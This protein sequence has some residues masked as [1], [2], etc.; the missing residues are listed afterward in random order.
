MGFKRH[1]NIVNLPM[2][3]M[4]DKQIRSLVH[5]I[6]GTT[7]I[8][9]RN[10]CVAKIYKTKLQ[11][12][13]DEV[14]NTKYNFID[15]NGVRREV[16]SIRIPRA[17]KEL[18][19]EYINVSSSFKQDIQDNMSTREDDL[20][21]LPFFNKQKN[22]NTKKLYSFLLEDMDKYLDYKKKEIDLNSLFVKLNIPQSFKSSFRPVVKTFNT[23]LNN[24]SISLSGLARDK[25]RAFE[26]KHEK[27]KLDSQLRK[28]SYRNKLRF[29]K[30]GV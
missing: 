29:K 7:K 20:L 10:M 3:I 5:W 14:W 17:P 21:E 22:L 4:L 8:N 2:K 30:Q 25:L 16:N 1:F 24:G 12:I 15:P 18:R 6:I 26:E 13:T 11:V 23:D 19:R 27:E 9:S 28:K